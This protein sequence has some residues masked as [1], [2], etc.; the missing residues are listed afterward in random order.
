M[1]ELVNHYYSFFLATKA[2]ILFSSN[3][4]KLFLWGKR[5]FFVR[6]EGWVEFV[7]C[8]IFV[9]F[10]Y[11]FFHILRGMRPLLGLVGVIMRPLLGLVGVV[12]PLILMVFLCLHF[13]THLFFIFAMCPYGVT[14]HTS[15]EPWRFVKNDNG[16]LEI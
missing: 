10:L 14:N 1:Y 16:K 15:V 5:Q 7:M 2:F 12:I 13:F 3:F 11:V 4:L 6:S 9:W 8:F